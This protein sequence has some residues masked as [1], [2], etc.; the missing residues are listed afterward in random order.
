MSKAVEYYSQDYATA[1][2]RLLDAADNLGANVFSIQHA[3]VNGV[4]NEP[5]YVDLLRFGVPDAKKLI[6]I[7]SG[8]HGVEG[9]CGSACQLGLLHESL[10]SNLPDNTALL[11]VH[12][13]NPHGFSHVRRVNECNVDINRNFWPQGST[14]PR[15]ENYELLHPHLVP[16]DWFGDSRAQADL[17]VLRFIEERGKRAYQ[18]ALTAGQYT[19]PDGIFFGGNE[20]CWSNHTWQSIIRQYMSGKQELLFVDV[21]TGVG[22]YGYGE[23]ILI[24]ST[25][26]NALSL[27]RSWLGDCVTSMHGEECI[28]AIVE[29]PISNAMRWHIGGQN[30]MTVALE[31]GTRPLQQALD[32][33]RADNWLYLQEDVPERQRV[34]I[35]A[36]IRD[37]FYVEEQKWMEMI[38]D[39]FVEIF[40]RGLDG[41]D[42]V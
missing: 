4:D 8:T 32:A 7:G 3:N 11:L 33:L 38:W 5:L 23:P 27:A 40:R 29:G 42:R 6:V 1:R 31:Y 16:D 41:I 37:A 34:E 24:D 39:R 17:E 13:L 30:F 28:S 25:Y 12:A 2:K 36:Q 15:N 18:E 20:P 10:H 14:R 9:F 22:P 21:H 35:K 26:N 19:H